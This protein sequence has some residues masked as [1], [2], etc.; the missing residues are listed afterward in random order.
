MDIKRTQISQGLVRTRKRKFVDFEEVTDRGS[1]SSTAPTRA[2]TPSPALPSHPQTPP[3]LAPSASSPPTPSNSPP[4]DQQ[5]S[6]NP[7]SI[8]D[9]VDFEDLAEQLI[10]NARQSHS[11]DS[12]EGVEANRSSAS[13]PSTSPPNPAA[14]TSAPLPQSNSSHLKT[15][16]PLSKLFRYPGSSS[17]PWEG[18]DYYWKGGVRN[19]DE[20]MQAHEQSMR[21]P[22]Q[23]HDGENN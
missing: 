12:E 13:N 17:E 23:D 3:T 19:L 10:E 18:L 21:E 5:A 15:S 16:I 1:S 14:A 7:M 4:S 9:M 2:A 6:E 22:D 8:D 11:L 20:E